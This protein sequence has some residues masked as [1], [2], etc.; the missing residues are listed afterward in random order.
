MLAH[1]LEIIE[2]CRAICALTPV[3][4]ATVLNVSTTVV[5]DVILPSSRR[6]IEGMPEDSVGINHLNVYDVRGIL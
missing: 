3:V 1:G 5:V 6:R 4:F 2:G